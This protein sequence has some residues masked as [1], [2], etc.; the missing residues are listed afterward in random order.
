MR[1]TPDTENWPT[2]VVLS[3]ISG[4]LLCDSFG[5]LHA[6]A[7]RVDGGPIWTHEFASKG[8]FDRLR[9]A[10]LRQHPAL[11]AFTTDDVNDKAT[12]Q[13]AAVRGCQEF[14][15]TLSIA[16]P[17]RPGRNKSP[18]DVLQEVAPDKPVFLVV[19]P[20]EPTP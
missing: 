1:L 16:R 8:T 6:L 18:L 9:D 12:A 17:E 4:R 15:T 11:T 14:G 5:D 2:P 20:K 13:I 19:V 10:I 3:L 7:E